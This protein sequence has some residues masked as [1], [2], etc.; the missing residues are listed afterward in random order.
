M[1]AVRCN[2][3][4]ER[5]KLKAAF[6]VFAASLPIC[7]HGAAA[8]S[9]C[10]AYVSDEKRNVLAVVD[11]S[12]HTLSGLLP[13]GLGYDSTGVALSRDGQRVIVAHV[14]SDTVSVVD[15]S[16]LE[17]LGVA[18]VPDPIWV[19][20]SPETGT[21]AVSSFSSTY[22]RVTL[23]DDESF[24]VVASYVPGSSPGQVA[25]GR[26]GVF[27]VSGTPAHLIDTATG[28][29]TALDVQARNAGVALSPDRST[30]FIGAREEVAVVD[31]ATRRVVDRWRTGIDWE[32][33]HLAISVDGGRLFATFPRQEVVRIMETGSGETLGEFALPEDVRPQ[34]CIPSPDGRRVYVI[35]AS[36]VLTF[37]VDSRALVATMVFDPR[38]WGAV[39]PDGATLWVAGSAGLYPVDTLRNVVVGAVDAGTDPTGLAVSADQSTLFTANL[40]SGT[41]SVVDTATNRVV[42][43]LAAGGAPLGI[44]V[45]DARG[46][47][48][49]TDFSS[50]GGLTSLNLSSGVSVGLVSLGYF[51][52]SV[53]L[54]PDRR[55]AVVANF[56]SGS[57]DIV[58]LDDFRV[59]DTIVLLGGRTPNVR[60]HPDLPFALVTDLDDDLLHVFDL[61]AGQEVAPIVTGSTC[62]GPCAV[63]ISPDGR[64]AYAM[65]NN[66]GTL[67]VID[68]QTFDVARSLNLA[69]P[70]S[71][72]SCGVTFAPNGAFAYVANTSND[73][74][75]IID[76][77]EH[78]IVGHI[79]VPDSQLAQVAF[80][81][82]TETSGERHSVS[83]HADE[84][85]TAATGMVRLDVEVRDTRPGYQFRM[86]IKIE[87]IGGDLAAFRHEL[88]FDPSAFSIVPDTCQLKGV[89]SGRVGRRM[90]F[91]VSVVPDELERELSRLRVS[92]QPVTAFHGRIGREVI[93]DGV[94][95]SCIVK[96]RSNATP[97]EYQLPTVVAAGEWAGGV[98]VGVVEAEVSS[99]TVIGR[100]PSETCPG[101]CDRNGF[102]SIGELI[103]AVRIATGDRS[104]SDCIAADL[105]GDG[106]VSVG[107]LVV[108][109]STSLN[110]CEPL[111]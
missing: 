46:R 6:I 83:R 29:M 76:A 26:D 25:W 106:R 99:I 109:V 82:P 98:P 59:E 56:G 2:E 78:E 67:D 73:T 10:T 90:V 27:I 11:P 35:A 17:I 44:A 100:T 88:R 102:V 110:G 66:H 51:T 81:C 64:W 15:R 14:G 104:L 18:L 80:A 103:T 111:S 7:A 5:A 85:A 21:V 60:V 52:S 48:Y 16:T 41:V 84:L 92:Y 62:C 63:D 4:K 13:V 89:P 20:V 12:T 61:D 70:Y 8:V 71:P 75:T 94:F 57:I 30:A 54:T 36:S 79:P 87:S 96:V 47:L 39:E 72:Q 34:S 42:D 22:P 55:R 43:R 108:A 19:A 58:G 3:T 107:D 23:L 33:E 77:V 49:V 105:G 1:I 68:L 86:P 32:P 38:G 95:Y 40:Q 28:R 69:S 50:P 65:H 31:I 53:G 24:E 45:D 101:D 74:I 91:S 37:E 97:G 93:G 9:S